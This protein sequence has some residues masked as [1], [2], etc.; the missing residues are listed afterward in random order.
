[1]NREKIIYKI[2]IKMKE[3]LNNNIQKDTITL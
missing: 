3:F 1:M 2:Y